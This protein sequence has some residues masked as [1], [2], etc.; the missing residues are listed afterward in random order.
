MK[1]INEALYS[2]YVKYGVNENISIYKGEFFLI[3]DNNKYT[4]EG[5]IYYKI[6]TNTGINFKCDIYLKRNQSFTIKEYKVCFI[7][8]PG[9]DKCNVTIQSWG[10]GTI[11]GYI[12]KYISKGN[13]KEVSNIKF[14][15]INF[16]NIPGRAIKYKNKGYS[17]RLKFDVD[18]YKVIIDKRPDF[19]N[20]LYNKLKYEEGSV[21]THIGTIVRK[22]GKKIDINQSQEILTNI[23]YALMFISGRYV[24]ICN[25]EGYNS[26]IKV[27]ERWQNKKVSPFKYTITW[28]DTI[29]D[30]KYLEKYLSLM[31]IKLYEE[32]IGIVFR[33]CI[34][35]YVE[36]CGDTTIEN[37]IVSVQIALETLA[38]AM[39]VVK[40]KKIS[41]EK[42][43][44]NRASTNIRLLLDMCNIEYN[45][46][47]LTVFSSN[48]KNKFDDG[49]HIVTDY[50]NSIVHPS[51][52][53]YYKH[54]TVQ[55]LWKI[56]QIGTRYLE[57]VILYSSG[58]NGVYS[59]RLNE[60][61]FGE[62]EAVPWAQNE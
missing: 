23:E 49:P 20:E 34:E 43:K 26:N 17:G 5:E 9:F 37:R 53:N 55:E 56:L 54:F 13:V 42:F 30:A 57:L 29:S 2:K 7:E 48:I 62:F 39:L 27:Y 51:K 19:D 59:N 12:N 22:D 16:N 36:V 28:I 15:I 46:C 45:K 1:K 21:I 40:N 24:T 38:Y 25:I 6:N 44:D 35:W 32:Y 4:C 10:I 61:W 14:H 3:V 41:S 58:Y 18:I 47:D 8:A 11:S 52:K 50:R 33:H 60:K 31:C